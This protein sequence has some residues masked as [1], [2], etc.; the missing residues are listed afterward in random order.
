[1]D[2]MESRVRRIET[3]NRVLLAVLTIGVVLCMS[4]G[5]SQQPQELGVSS[6]LRAKRIELV[7]QA[8]RVVLEIGGGGVGNIEAFGEVDTLGRMAKLKITPSSIVMTSRFGDEVIKFMHVDDGA[9]DSTQPSLGEFRVTVHDG[10][11]NLNMRGSER[12][13]ADRMAS[14]LISCGV[15]QDSVA[16]AVQVDAGGP[17]GSSLWA[18]QAHPTSV[19]IAGINSGALGAAPRRTWSAVANREAV[20]LHLEDDEKSRS[21]RIDK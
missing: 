6:V 3:T 19:A 15:G 4:A 7:D 12:T 8:G 18:L 14:V 13:L 20:A 10:T 17:N 16:S 9:G 5:S 2:L 1:M 11:A 21:F